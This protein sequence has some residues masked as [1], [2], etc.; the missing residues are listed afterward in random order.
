[1]FPG[2]WITGLRLMGTQDGKRKDSLKVGNSGQFPLSSGVVYPELH[3]QMQMPFVSP[4]CSGIGMFGM[5]GNPL[6][7]L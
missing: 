4:V 2:N 6:M 5:A 3:V 7:H 1:M